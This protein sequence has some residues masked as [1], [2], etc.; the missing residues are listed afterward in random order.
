[1]LSIFDAS[2]L[3]LATFRLTHIFV[4]DTVGNFMRDYFDNFESGLGKS[5]SEL[6]HCPW[7]T[8]TWM[9]FFVLSLYLFVPI[10]R[11]FFMVLALAGIALIVEISARVIWKKANK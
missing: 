10:S 9:A 4:Y 7:C 6:V 3:V 5:L 8:S 2:I 1:M 11:F